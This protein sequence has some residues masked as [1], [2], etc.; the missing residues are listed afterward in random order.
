MLGRLYCAVTVIA[1]ARLDPEMLGVAIL[2]LRVRP[3]RNRKHQGEESSD[4][5]LGQ[6]R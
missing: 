2:G 4:N 6:R 3:G 1:G 5:D